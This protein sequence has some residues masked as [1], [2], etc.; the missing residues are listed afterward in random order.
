MKW[1]DWLCGA[2]ARRQGFKRGYRAGQ[3]EGQR[4]KEAAEAEAR[5]HLEDA[6]VEAR[7]LV[8]KIKSDANAAGYDK[9]FKKGRAEGGATGQKEGKLLAYQQAARDFGIRVPDTAEEL[10]LSEELDAAHLDLAQVRPNIY[11]TGRA[12]VVRVQTNGRRMQ[13]A[14]SYKTTPRRVRNS[15]YGTTIIHDADPAESLEALLKAIVTRNKLVDQQH[16]YATLYS[17]CMLHVGANGSGRSAEDYHRDVAVEFHRRLQTSEV[18]LEYAAWVGE[19]PED[20]LEIEDHELMTQPWTVLFSGNISHRVL[21][22]FKR[23]GLGEPGSSCR[24]IRDLLLV[25]S[26]DLL[27]VNDF[28]KKTLNQLRQGLRE[29]GLCLWGEEVPPP[30]PP[31]QRPGG[32][33]FRAID[34]GFDDE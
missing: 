16:R 32:R 5:Q 28:G 25:S 3:Q 7:K 1:W 8:G 33:E 30:P 9:G 26:D 23:V 11:N 14:F 29:H 19:D 31:E 22:A 13:Y 10:P 15:G 18:S 4:I 2:A 12:W 17:E 27:E 20:S 21:N 24:T 34:L 6:A